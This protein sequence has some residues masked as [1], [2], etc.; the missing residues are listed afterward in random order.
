MALVQKHKNKAQ[1]GHNFGEYGLKIFLKIQSLLQTYDRVDMVFDRYDGSESIQ[2]IERHKRGMSGGGGDVAIH[3]DETPIP[4]WNRFMSNEGN[5]VRLC[6]YLVAYIK[7]QASMLD[8]GMTVVVGGRCVV[9]TQAYR[10][11][12]GVCELFPRLFSDHEE[13]DTRMILHATHAFESC[14][15]VNNIFAG[16]WFSGDC[17]TPLQEDFAVVYSG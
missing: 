5:K 17:C 16:H 13:A 15:D 10:I 4:N 6:N 1:T 14:S 12:G 11:H 7:K 2:N 3:S 8:H 9:P